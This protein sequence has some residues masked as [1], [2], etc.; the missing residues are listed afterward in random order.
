MKDNL[1]KPRVELIPTKPLIA[2]AEVLGYG[3]RTYA[4][5]NW[6][7]GMSWEDTYASLQRHLLAWHDGESLDPGSGLSHLSHALCQLAFLSEFELTGTGEDDRFKRADA[8]AQPRAE[9]RLDAVSL[10]SDPL[11]GLEFVP[12]PPTRPNPS[13]DEERGL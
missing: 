12:R 11:P 2:M 7:A 9:V 10:V 4:P 13:K 1:L 6:R 8:T 5:N 3:A